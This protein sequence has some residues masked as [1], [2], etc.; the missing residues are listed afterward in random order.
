V[1][2][3]ASIPNTSRAIAIAPEI[4]DA[5]LAEG[6]FIGRKYSRTPVRAVATCTR[7]GLQFIVDK[8]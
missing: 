7:S 3:F 4:P 8:A 6:L 2:A 1:I 5:A